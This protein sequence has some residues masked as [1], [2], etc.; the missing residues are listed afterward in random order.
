MQRILLFFL[1]PALSIE[2][3]VPP[4]TLEQ[5]R[6]VYEYTTDILDYKIDPYT[7]YKYHKILNDL[8]KLGPVTYEQKVDFI[9]S[10]F[11]GTPYL[12]HQLIGS[13]DI[14]E[15]LTIDFRGLD[16]FTY[17]DYVEALR[18]SS[19]PEDF[20]TNLIKVRYI[21]SDVSFYHRRHFFTD[22]AQRN[23]V[24]AEDITRK[25]SQHTQSSN[26]ILNQK[27]NGDSYLPGLPP[28]MRTLNY[29]PGKAINN[30][31]IRHLKTGDL[32]G[33][34]TPLAGLDVTHVGLFINTDKGPVFRNASSLAKN[35]QVVDTPFLQYVTT[36]PG[37]IVLRTK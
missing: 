29:I 32:I 35:N 28:V 15:V 31:V 19:R 18:R 16:C 37:I 21:D 20:I 3:H 26:K 9:S 34:Y 10:R 6:G 23:S 1:I 5:A 14:P 24:L 2:C 7:L 12:S 33:I 8:A 36:K 25:I 13:R 30:Q 4:K 27:A 11:L 22:W 17:L